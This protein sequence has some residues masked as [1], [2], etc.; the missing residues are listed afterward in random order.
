MLQ[1]ISKTYKTNQIQ[2]WSELRTSQVDIVLAWNSYPKFPSLTEGL[3]K[4]N[5]NSKKEY[6]K[7][8]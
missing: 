2:H 7:K 1:G 3:A 5:L 8:L 4:F 6:K